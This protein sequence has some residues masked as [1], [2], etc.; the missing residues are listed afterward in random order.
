MSQEKRYQ[1]TLVAHITSY[2]RDIPQF[3]L[4]SLCFNEFR[5]QELTTSK[6]FRKT[7]ASVPNPSTEFKHKSPLKY[8]A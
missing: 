2:S 8:L 5:L 3:K 1:H 6:T 4:G 7:M